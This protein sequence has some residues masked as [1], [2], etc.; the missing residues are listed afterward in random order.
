MLF[1]HNT[2]VK[3]GD[4]TY[5]VQTEDRGTAHAL[6]DTTVYFRG[7]VLHRRTNNYFDLL[8]LDADR[9]QTLKLRVDE[10]HRIIVEQIQSGALSVALP[11][12]EKPAAAPGPAAPAPVA[13]AQTPAAV[14]ASSS[15]KLELRNPKTWLAGKRASLQIA[16]RDQAGKAA[17]GA[18]V[19][20]KVDGAAA[21]SEFSTVTDGAGNA[22]LEFEMPPLSNA[23]AALVVEAFKGN[24]KGQLRFQLKMKPRVPSAS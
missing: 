16:V 19:T 4:T 20:T 14:S 8:P 5:H 10:Q 23:E 9:E 6:I 7:R 2:N 18:I 21:P 24:T 3:A 22:Q 17:D 13:P 11:P 15:L 12:E 1:G